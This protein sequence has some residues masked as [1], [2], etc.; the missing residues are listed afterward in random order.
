MPSAVWTNDTISRVWT[1]FVSGGSAAVAEEPGWVRR[2]SAGRVGHDAADAVDVDRVVQRAQLR[3][4]TRGLVHP[5]RSRP[6]IGSTASVPFGEAGGRVVSDP[7]AAARI[8]TRM[9]NRRMI[10]DNTRVTYAAATGGKRAVSFF[11]R[12]FRLAAATAFVAALAVAFGVQLEAQTGL[13]ARVHVSGLAAPVGFVQDPTNGDVQFVVEQAGRIRVVQSGMLAPADFLD[14][15]GAISAGGERGLLGLAFAPDYESSGR[16]YVN[17]TNPA[18]D[19]VIARFLRATST[20]PIA[21]ASSRFDLRWP[22]GPRYIAQPYSNHNAGN[23]AFGPDGYLYIGLGDGGSGNDPENRAQNPAELLGKMLRIDVNVIDSDA[24]GYAFHRP[25]RSCTAA[26]PACC[27]RSGASGCETPGATRSIPRRLAA[28]AGSLSPTSG[29]AQWEEVDYEP[30]GRG[31]RNYGWRV[32]EG[33]HNNITSPGPAYSHW[34]IRSTVRPCRRS[35]GHG[36]LRLSRKR[37]AG[38]ISRPLLLCGLRAGARVV[39]GADHRSGDGRGQRVGGGRAYLRTGR[40]RRARQHQLVRRRLARRTVHRQS[41][42]RQRRSDHST[43]SR[44]LPPTNLRIIRGHRAAGT[45][46]DASGPHHAD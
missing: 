9:L 8:A 13:R 27:R 23:L 28:P 10:S 3:R 5:I 2:G 43:A 42:R 41:H 24:N 29:R 1:P 45:P 40:W 6:V 37:P 16:F 30:A 35:V 22:S 26:R 32:R 7:H 20:P 46:E 14:L 33:A 39:A 36:R 18:G 15:R 44:P 19:T 38:D 25:I 21:N 34:S 11:M 31:G 12:L 4:I 17:F